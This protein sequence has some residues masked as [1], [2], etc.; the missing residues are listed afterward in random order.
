LTDIRRLTVMDDSLTRMINEVRERTHLLNLTHEIRLPEFDTTGLA[1]LAREA[2]SHR[3]LLAPI[4]DYAKYADLMPPLAKELSVATSVYQEFERQFRL[5]EVTEAARL[6]HES[7]ASAS[8]AVKLLGFDFENSLKSAMTSMDVPWLRPDYL[9]ESVR[10]F[11]ELQAIGAAFNLRSPYEDALSSA[12]RGALGDWRQVTMLPPTIFDNPVT[13][14][15][16]YVHLGFDFSLTEFTP[17]AFDESMA[18]AGF[19]P[20]EGEHAGE[21]KGAGVARNI[22]AYHYLL[23]LEMEVRNFIDCVMTEAFGPDWASHQTPTGM[24]DQWKT[25]QQVHTKNG[26]VEQPLIAYADFTDYIRIIERKDNW[27]KVFEAVFGRRTDVQESFV[28]L[29]PVRAC[30]MHARIITL[31]DELLLRA[32]SR[33]IRLAISN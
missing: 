15:E 11:A 20:M 1:R 26:D 9:T 10:A 7:I 23:E 14:S 21:R 8:R 3:R 5:P 33:R 6:A 22:R 31:D 27:S 17:A 25:K 16:F 29:F 24:L 28:R 19:P 30:T 18:L 32:E 13:R 4:L 12:L 2:E